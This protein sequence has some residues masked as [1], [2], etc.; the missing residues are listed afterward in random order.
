MIGP[1][2]RYLRRKKPDIVISA[3]DHLN[4][5]VLI[6]ALVTRSPAT[7]SVSS[8]VTPFDTYSKTLLSKRWFLKQI[9]GIVQKRATALICVS[10]DMVKQYRTIFK[11]SRHQCIYN[12][13]DDR[14]FHEKAEEAVDEP[15][16]LEK[17]ASIIVAAGRLAPEKGFPDLILAVKQLS[18]VRDVKLILL[19]EGPMRGELECLIEENGLQETVKLVGF[20]P[21]PLKYYWRAD[22]FALSSYVEGLPNVLVEAMMCGCTPVS[23]NCPTGPQEVLAD[24]KYGYLV[25]VRNPNA[26]AAGISK[27]LDCPIPATILAEGIF[28][29]T[30][31]EVYK[32]Y[33]SA[34][35][36]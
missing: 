9:M 19:G 23:T 27:A 11:N 22:V 8:R 36:L 32:K 5:V 4:A 21:N 18:K 28:E 12:V 6:S 30:E 10:K 24:G 25:P 34:L 35:G 17:N 13:I 29:F 7:I 26:L 31:D 33:V 16:L 14:N 20:Q 2:A 15:W 3:E 1:T